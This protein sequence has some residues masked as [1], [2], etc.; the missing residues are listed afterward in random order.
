MSGFYVD[1]DEQRQK[2][3]WAEQRLLEHSLVRPQKPRSYAAE[4]DSI[5]SSLPP[6][7]RK[8][9]YYASA[10]ET[11]VDRRAARFR[12]GLPPPPPPDTTNL[13]RVL[14][15]PPPPLQNPDG[16]LVAPSTTGHNVRGGPN[17]L[18]ASL[19]PQFYPNGVEYGH[20][21]DPA[22]PPIPPSYSES[23]TTEH[24]AWRTNPQGGSSSPTGLSP[25]QKKRLR[26]KKKREGTARPAPYP[27]AVDQQSYARGV[28][29]SPRMPVPPTITLPTPIPPL[30]PEVEPSFP[31]VTQRACN[32]EC[33][34]RLP[35]GSVTRV[36]CPLT[37]FPH[38]NQPHLVKLSPADPTDDTEIFLGF[39]LPGE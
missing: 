9:G 20:G 16:S 11:S 33:L 21:H 8:E 1:A 30:P 23:D 19:V 10:R 14:A 27:L 15:P 31:N 26:R 25:S 5:E 32:A 6:V 7:F 18:P 4:D 12:D 3:R 35:N 28:G 29:V 13:Q 34:L 37:P 39:W 36:R 22:A 38:P 17:P 24:A 2:A